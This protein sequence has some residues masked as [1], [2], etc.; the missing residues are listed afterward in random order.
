M[1]VPLRV[2]DAA[3]RGDETDLPGEIAASERTPLVIKLLVVATFIVILNETIMIN[4]VPRLMMDFSI[5]PRAAQWLSTIFMLTMAAVIP[6]TG[7]FLQRVTTR[8][9]YAVAMA[10]FCT[11]TVIGAVAPAFPVL[12]AGR[13]VQAAGTA[14][15]MPLLMTTLMVVVPESARGRVMGTVTMAMSCAP[16]LGPAVSGVILQLGSW[17]LIFVFILP[18]AVL[19]AV[20]GLRR[21]E[22]VGETVSGSVHWPSVLLA[23]LGFS[24]LLFGLSEIGARDGVTVGL[25]IT[26]GGALVA[27]FAAVQ[28]R[29]AQ[30][31]RPLLD[32][33]TLVHR[34]FRVSLLVMAAS[35]M[36]FFGAMFLLP[37]YLQDVRDLTELQTGLLVM[38][39]GLAMGLLGPAVGRVYDRFGARL[40]VIP[41]CAVAMLSL[42]ALA[43]IGR[44]TPYPLLL[45]VHILLMA[46]LA[47]VFTPLFSV[48][49]GDLPASLYSHGSS[50]FGTIMQVSGAMGT[51]LLVVILEARSTRLTDGGASDVDALVGGMRW[52][53]ATAALIAIALTLIALWIPN[54]PKGAGA[55]ASPEPAPA[56]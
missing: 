4:A 13:V 27:G 34:S 15:M 50:L 49:L 23:A 44:D 39:G 3:H 18:V 25:I 46:S 47:A 26:G 30:R 32:L 42:G 41:G 35:N 12:L 45:V 54:R 2:D 56:V 28:L 10:T 6:L 51:A 43:T 16:A 21:L 36:A 40:L 17:R 20:A 19:V 37:L 9:A 53:F 22:N 14:V 24:G 48:G 55:H 5:S 29:L 7:W 52:A 1:T 31:G 38:P 33:R 11:G 8:T